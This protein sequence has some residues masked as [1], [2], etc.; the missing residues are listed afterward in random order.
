MK[1]FGICLTGTLG[2]AVAGQSIP[3]SATEHL[4][5]IQATGGG[6]LPAVWSASAADLPNTLAIF[7]SEE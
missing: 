7:A 2:L 6:T 5:A 3:L 1:H 4:Q